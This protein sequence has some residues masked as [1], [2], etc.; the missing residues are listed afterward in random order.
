MDLPPP[1]YFVQIDGLYFQ[2]REDGMQYALI[3][4]TDASVLSNAK[5]KHPDF[6]WHLGFKVTGG[7]HLSHD[8]WALKFQFLHF[9]ARTTTQI[10]DEVIFPT[11]G[12]PLR[13]SD[14]FAK[15]AC[16]R[17]R[18]HLGFLDVNLEKSWEVS[19]N[20]C[21]LPFF[22]LRF[23]GIR[24]KSRITYGGGSLF[25]NFEEELS[26]KNKFWGVGP[27]IGV[28]GFWH[29]LSCIS[30]F[31]RIG[32][33]FLFGSFYVHQDEQKVHTKKEGRLKLFN[34]FNQV[35]SVSEMAIGL[36]FHHF[37]EKQ[38]FEFFIRLNYE[39]YLLFGQNQHMRFVCEKVP[40]KYISNLGNLT[41]HG[42]TL[43]LGFNF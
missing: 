30:I 3:D 39:I 33:N 43:G 10:K 19:N 28:E 25:L 31:S 34:E 11:W 13:A 8:G 37:F 40:G 38:C 42:W 16:N 26:M 22:G 41:L 2:A 7:V 29:I 5:V 12:H 23:A 35:C 4:K 6:K 1:P 27:Q 9:H 17:W 36:D 14:G 20:L 18:L 21:F 24:H 32:E 15:N